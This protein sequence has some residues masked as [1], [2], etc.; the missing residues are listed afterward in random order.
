MKL[1]LRM[2]IVI[3]VLVLIAAIFFFRRE[4]YE[5]SDNTKSELSTMFTNDY[6]IATSDHEMLFNAILEPDSTANKA[7]ETILKNLTVDQQEDIKNKIRI[8]LSKDPNVEQIQEQIQEREKASKRAAKSKR[9]VTV[10]GGGT[11]VKVRN[12]KQKQRVT[13]PQ[14]NVQSDSTTTLVRMSRTPRNSNTSLPKSFLCK[15]SARGG[16]YD[17][18][19]FNYLAKIKD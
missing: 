2:G 14:P 4:G 19:F 17:C 12:Q 16:G 10:T 3:L 15:T 5:L 11:E 7:A 9:S 6:K 8:I 13:E 1:K 18:S